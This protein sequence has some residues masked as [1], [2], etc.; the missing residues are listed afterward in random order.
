MPADSKTK[1]LKVS[2][3]VCLVCSLL[4]SAAAVTLKPLQDW[5]RLIDKKKNILIAGG[6]YERGVDIAARYQERIDPVLVELKTG[7]EVGKEVD[8][9]LSVET[10]DIKEVAK[11]LTY[12]VDV[13]PERDRADIGRKPR[14][15]VVHRVMKGD[16]LAKLILPVYGKG[17]WSTLYGFLA[18]EGD[19]K[20]IAGITFYEHGETPGLGGEVDNPLW[21]QQWEGK[22]AF[23][24]TGAVRIEVIKGRVDRSREEAKY[25]VDGLAGATLTTRGV[26]EFVRFWLG[27]DGYGPYFAKLSEA[28]Q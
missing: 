6:L 11:D 17:L 8:G 16:R 12:G 10:F 21:K 3:G 9:E 2:L 28:A 18:L 19:L 5:N 26:D 25:Q 13:P 23:D 27:E 20:T 24:E 14:Y 15:V 4:V 22:L 1:A 7:N